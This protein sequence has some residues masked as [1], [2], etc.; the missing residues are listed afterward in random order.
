LKIA[1]FSRA[2]YN[3]VGC[4][5]ASGGDELSFSAFHAPACGAGDRAWF[6]SPPQVT[7]TGSGES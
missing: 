7:F 3:K 2:V 5:E 6:E 4:D 1:S